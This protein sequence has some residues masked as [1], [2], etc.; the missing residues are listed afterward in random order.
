M[1]FPRLLSV[2][3][4]GC[5]QWFQNKFKMWFKASSLITEIRY[6]RWSKWAINCVFGGAELEK[7]AG[8]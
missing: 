3:A 6:G 8:G 2:K 1:T 5:M 4:G 7:I